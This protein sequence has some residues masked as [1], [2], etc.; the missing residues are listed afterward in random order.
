MSSTLGAVGSA[1]GS[2]SEGAEAELRRAVARDGRLLDVIERTASVVGPDLFGS[3]VRL[4]SEVLG[5]RYVFVAEC[6]DANANQAK[7]LSFWSNSEQAENFDFCSTGGPCELVMSGQILHVADGLRERFPGQEALEQLGAE[8]YLGYPL[9]NSNGR[10]IGHIAAMDVGRME[11]TSEDVAILK[12]LA[13][14]TAAELERRL[15]EQAQRADLLRHG[16]ERFRLAQE[17]A[18]IGTWDMDVRNGKGE[19]SDN[20]WGIYGLD[21]GDCVPGYEAWI[22]LVHP[23]DRE[24]VDAAIQAALRGE[25]SYEEEFRIVWPDGTVRWLVGKASVF[26]GD[27]G[28]PVRMIGVDYDV[29]ERKEA[30]QKLQRLYEE[31]EG[32]V[33]ERTHELREANERLTREAAER[34]RMEEQRRRLEQQMVA[35]QKLE[36]LGVLTGGVAHDFN[37]LLSTIMGNSELALSHLPS[38]SAARRHVERSVDAAERASDL[39]QQLLSYSGRTQ[40]SAR[41]LDLSV[42]VADMADLLE[43]SSGKKVR[44]QLRTAE[45]PIPVRADPTQVRQ[46]VMNLITN[47]AEAMPEGGSVEI[48]TSIVESAPA[49]MGRLYLSGPATSGPYA[50]LS[51]SDAGAGLNRET[52]SKIFDPFFTTKFLGRGLGL[53][54]VLGIVASHQGVIAV[55]DREGGG[56]VFTTLLPLVDRAYAAEDLATDESAWRGSGKVLVVDDEHDVRA[57]AACLL[58]HMGFETVEASGGREAVE[59]F[60]Q[61]HAEIRAV[62]MDHVMP[63]M[64][65]AEASRRLREIDASTPVVITS[66]YGRPKVEGPDEGG[67][68]VGYIRKPYRQERLGQGLRA[69]LGDG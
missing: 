67:N 62:L 56:A 20:Y 48:R 32:R 57:T 16:E 42:L 11:P 10:I 52:C 26:R 21:V 64:D 55:D 12:L 25:A 31:L 51:V 33:E 30:E 13:A 2:L 69:A 17:A 22:Q 54:A 61:Q 68:V 14:R 19:W 29:T 9:T 58:R 1:S 47:A 28:A 6:V 36:S 59:L 34:A 40:T 4:L 49:G 24:P 38:E 15:I 39:T 45:D 65:G 46:V 63:G 7:T 66:G 44:L 50:V 37:N 3:A 5:V 8:S 53:A 35:A 18:G 43:V 27:D 41:T 60:E 23:E